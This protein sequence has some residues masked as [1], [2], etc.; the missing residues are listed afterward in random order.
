[1]QDDE[2]RKNIPKIKEKEQAYKDGWN[3]AMLKASNIV[4]SI[5]SNRGN[6][7]QIITILKAERK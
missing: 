6:E 2:A 7:K 4:A 5:D 3:D 1:M